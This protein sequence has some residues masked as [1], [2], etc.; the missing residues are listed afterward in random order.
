M[1]LQLDKIMLGVQISISRALDFESRVSGGLGWGSGFDARLCVIEYL[2]HVLWK[3]G[4]V[5]P[6]NEPAAGMET[7]A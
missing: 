3:S 1:I 6:R 7:F 2:N 4:A 5:I